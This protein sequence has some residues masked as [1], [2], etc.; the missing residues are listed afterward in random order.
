MAFIY[1]IGIQCLCVARVGGGGDSGFGVE[2]VA[3]Q[4]TLRNS[5]NIFTLCTAKLPTPSAVILLCTSSI[6]TLKTSDN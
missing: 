2:E 5:R 4:L 6:S 3:G 1:G